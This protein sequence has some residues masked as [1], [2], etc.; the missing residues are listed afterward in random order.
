MSEDVELED[1]SGAEDAI[2]PDVGVVREHLIVHLGAPYEV[3]E[4]R[5]NPVTGSPIE[6]L[7]IAYFAPGG[8]QAPV[9]FSTCGL[10]QSL[11]ENGRRMEGLFMMRPAPAKP[12]PVYDLLAAFALYPDK[13]QVSVGIGDVIPGGAELEALCPMDALLVLPPVQ[14]VEGFQRVPRW[15]QQIVDLYWLVPVFEREAE[16]ALQHGPEALL[17]N[18]AAQG[19]DLTDLRRDEANTVITPEDAAE[20]A[21]K[22]ELEDRKRPRPA[23]RMAAPAPMMKRR[24]QPTSKSFEAEEAED[25]GFVVRR[26]GVKTAPPDATTVVDRPVHRPSEPGSPEAP[27]RPASAAAALPGGPKRF[28]VPKKDKP[29]K[30]V[31]TSKPKEARDPAAEKKA[32]IEALKADAK[33]RAER[34]KKDREGGG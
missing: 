21:K 13:H 32:R 11:M 30:P 19:L 7:E 15:D 24:P 2:T 10:S 26:R 1:G 23:A 3:C 20:M 22:R 25:G 17:M 31:L 34:A 9:L 27:G 8:M 4:L 14:F 16:Y 28:E 33:A 18:F 6:L 12:Q 29:A 5:R